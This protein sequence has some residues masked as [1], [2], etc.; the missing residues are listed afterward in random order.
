MKTKAKIEEIR[1]LMQADQM[2][3]EDDVK[4]LDQLERAKRKVKALQDHLKPRISATIEAHGA[5]RLMVGS[6]Q[7]ELKR[8]ARNS[9]AWKP[10]CYSLVDEAAILSV[11]ESFTIPYDVD[12]AKVVS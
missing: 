5:G 1:P 3:T 6:R 8:S 4:L 12:S 2:L 11:Q 9:V 7:V 10:L